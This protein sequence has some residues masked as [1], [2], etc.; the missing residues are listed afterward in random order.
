MLEHDPRA[1]YK[2]SLALRVLVFS[3]VASIVLVSVLIVFVRF[4]W[5]RFV[6]PNFG[7][8]PYDSN[9]ILVVP[10]MLIIAA[11]LAKMFWDAAE[12]S[13]GRTKLRTK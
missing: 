9:P 4:M 8:N 13:D 2:P 5:D 3:L 10:A 6:A 7:L 11:F 12:A 1:A